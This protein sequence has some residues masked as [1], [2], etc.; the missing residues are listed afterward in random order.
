MTIR[1][2]R[3]AHDLAVAATLFQEY[4]DALGVDLSFQ[5]F[6][7]EVSGLPGAYAP[8]AGRILLAFE[9]GH[10]AGCVALRPLAA[11][12]CEMKRLYV[13][14]GYRASGLGRRLAEAIMA[15]GRE[16][17]Y[18]RMRLD[19]LPSMGAAQALYRSVGFRQIDPYTV[20]PV[21]GT[22]FLE[23]SLQQEEQAFADC[24]GP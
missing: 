23:A 18:E 1:E 15:S 17:G 13:R 19:T 5:G 6:A 7:E 24:P 4:A 3:G 11:D 22:R 20:N 14:P 8:P 9:A 12:V 2:A 21:P 16:L 10:A